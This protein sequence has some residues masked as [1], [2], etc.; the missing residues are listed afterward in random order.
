[1][2]VQLVGSLLDQS[3]LFHLIVHLF[4][5]LGAINKP[6]FRAIPC[7]SSHGSGTAAS[8]AKLY[9]ILA[10]GGE[11]NGTQ[12]LSGQAISALE[13]PA[14]TGVDQMVGMKVSRGMGTWLIPIVVDDD[15]DKV[16]YKLC[17]IFDFYMVGLKC[18]DS[19]IC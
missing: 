3:F 8:V 11:Y 5:F 18:F 6:E 4:Q 7:G 1:M 19:F 17:F 13:T 15:F 14:M 9:G 16:R 10:N 12:V 2:G